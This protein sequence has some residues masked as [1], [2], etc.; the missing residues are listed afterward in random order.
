[1][2]NTLLETGIYLSLW[3][4]SAWRVWPKVIYWFSVMKM[5]RQDQNFHCWF[6]FKADFWP[7]RWCALVEPWWTTHTRTR[8]TLM[9]LGRRTD[10]QPAP[11]D[12]QSRRTRMSHTEAS[13]GPPATFRRTASAAQWTGT[14]LRRQGTQRKACTWRE[15]RDPGGHLERAELWTG[16]ETFLQTHSCHWTHQ[17]TAG[18]LRFQPLCKLI[19]IFLFFK[20]EAWN[21]INKWKCVIS[22][23][24]CSNPDTWNTITAPWLPLLI[25]HYKQKLWKVT[26]ASI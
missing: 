2:S 13:S 4:R 8:R 5:I 12:R 22:G 3:Q 24:C 17:N 26:M 20:E 15:G 23:G 10:G 21:G 19:C 14:C 1:M 16:I 9:P 7:G 18:N 11:C 6:F 25:N